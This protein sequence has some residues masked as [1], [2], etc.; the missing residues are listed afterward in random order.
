MPFLSKAQRAWMY[1]NEPEM[2]KKWAKHTPKGAEL[3]DRVTV[4]SPEKPPVS[5]RFTRNTRFGKT[6]SVK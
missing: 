4:K 6:H 3:P 1:K 5:S 2:A